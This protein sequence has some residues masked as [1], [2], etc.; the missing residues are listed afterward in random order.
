MAA[1]VAVL[2]D[3]ETLGAAGETAMGTHTIDWLQENEYMNDQEKDVN[4][5]Q[6]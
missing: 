5:G 1:A 6:P 3:F 4:S 2:L